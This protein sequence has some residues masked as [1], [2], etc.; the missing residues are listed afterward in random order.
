MSGPINIHFIYYGN[1]ND[2]NERDILQNFFTNVDGTPWFQTLRQYS[3]LANTN[4]TG[5]I[6]LTHVLANEY[7]FGTSLTKQNHIDIINEA[8][9]KNF[10]PVETNALYYVLSSKDVQ[11]EGFC[12]DY[13]GYHSHFTRP[14]NTQLL[15][16]Y[17]GNAEQQCAPGCATGNP[18]IS[19][20][21]N[22]GIDGMINIMAHEM[23]ESLNDPF[24]SAW[25]DSK[26]QESADKCN[27]NFGPTVKADNNA[28]YNMIVSGIKYNIQMNWNPNTAECEIGS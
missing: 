8:I 6:Q 20:N 3:N 27:F 16:A 14:D 22:V 1:W 5:P 9:D 17:V 11:S 21:S 4:I 7:T 13:C 19:P 10:L 18:D 24:L 26:G 12:K 23:I 25:Y 15:F 28:N 2:Q